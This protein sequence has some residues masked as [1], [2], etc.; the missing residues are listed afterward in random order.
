MVS[1]VSPIRLE[2][3]LGI[4]LG[5]CFTQFTIIGLLFSY[6][7]FFT[8]LESE[9]GWSRALLSGCT[10]I[11]F[12]VMGLLA[13]FGGRLSDRYGPRPVLAGAGTLVGLGYALLS[14][15]STPWQLFSSSVSSSASACPVTTW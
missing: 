13:S 2:G 10:S 1:L 14:Q 15:V 3:R 9:F 8:A 6:G 5:V 11:A 12:L 7:V 4:V